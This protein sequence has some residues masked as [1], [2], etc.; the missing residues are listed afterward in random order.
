[1]DLGVPHNEL[2]MLINESDENQDGIIQYEE[3]VPLAVDM[4]TTFTARRRAIMTTMEQDS[5]ADFTVYNQMRAQDI[6]KIIARCMDRFNDRAMQITKSQKETVLKQSH[7]RA[8][9]QDVSQEM[10]G[11]IAPIE[12]HRLAHAMPHNSFG[13]L[14]YADFPA[15][16]ERIRFLHLK[17]K[18]YESQGGL[19]MTFLQ[20]CAGLEEQHYE[21]L[22]P[23]HFNANR[24]TRIASAPSS[25]IPTGFLDFVDLRKM[26]M[27]SST[28]RVRMSDKRS[29]LSS[30]PSS[31]LT[32]RPTLRSTPRHLYRA[33]P[34]LPCP[35][36]PCPALPCPALPRARCR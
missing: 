13:K 32:T 25:F 3:F 11:V 36:L 28:V 21:L 10:G 33:C 34:A 7:F 1:M 5:M 4:I 26:M 9:L 27:E 12:I 15:T 18:Y 19:L 30:C 8:I 31:L 2:R 20:D 24:S 17:Q 22:R 16:F 35:A 29:P 6:D 14:I 23:K